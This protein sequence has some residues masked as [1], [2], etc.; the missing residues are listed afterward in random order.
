[1]DSTTT[2]THSARSNNPLGTRPLTDAHV[3]ARRRA[4]EARARGGLPP[5]RSPYALLASLKELGGRDG[6][7]DAH[8]RTLELLMQPIPDADWRR[9]CP[10]NWRPV[11]ALASERG[12][13]P[14]A[15]RAQVNRLMELGAV[16]F[17]DSPNYHRYRKPGEGDAPDD[18]YGID[19]APCILLAEEARARAAQVRAERTALDR[20]RHRASA[21]RRQIRAALLDPASR[22][23]LGERAGAIEGDLA[24][25]DPGRLDRLA[26]AVLEALVERL[27][28]LLALCERLIEAAAQRV[29]E[30]VEGVVDKPLKPRVSDNNSFRQGG[31]AL[32]AL[33]TLQPNLVPPYSCSPTGHGPNED[34]NLPSVAQ[35]VEALPHPLAR[36]LP[37][38]KRVAG[39]VGLEDLV[40]ACR[41]YRPR[42]GISRGAWLDAERMIGAVH[43]AIVLVITA[44]RSAEDWPEERRVRNPGGFFRELS[45]RAAGGRA[46]L[47]GSV[48]GIVARNLAP[49]RGGNSGRGLP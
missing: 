29:E 16:S 46:D 6:W 21:L 23:A 37:T 5:G 33:T 15:F 13:T 28:A 2:R 18:V 49:R 43:C 14:R 22:D 9:G 40:A 12:V 42:L 8:V 34:R 45:R 47:L 1:M 4:D 10:V 30:L 7:T 41:A 25:V 39:S 20:L 38:N 48:H 35:L 11:K 27:H 19:L 26:R 36:I 32:P 44:A 17:N 3:R 31:S 24:A